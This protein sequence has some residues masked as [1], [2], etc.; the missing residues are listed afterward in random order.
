MLLAVILDSMVQ[1]FGQLVYDV[2][3]WSVMRGVLLGWQVD[4]D[5]L[6]AESLGVD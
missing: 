3:S 2:T 1:W 6:G 5:L 4:R